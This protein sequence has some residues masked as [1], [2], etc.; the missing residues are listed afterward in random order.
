MNSN[1]NANGTLLPMTVTEGVV[2]NVM[3]S[4]RHEFLMTTREVASG[5]GTSVYV[6]RKAVVRHH[7][8][9]VDGFHYLGNE[10]IC[11]AA[12]PG[13]S[14]GTLWTKAGI[15]RLGFFVKSG[16]AKL[17]RDWAEHL[18]L[19]TLEGGRKQLPERTP[20]RI[21]RL[22]PERIIDLLNDVCMIEDR[23]LRERIAGKIMGGYSYGR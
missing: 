15:I 23:E 14:K 17:F 10:T 5:Y 11:H 3:P 8:D 18:I 22:T 12:S 9:F 16:R 7:S 6:I 19:S 21:N 13:S 2:V 4:T 20:R 1:K